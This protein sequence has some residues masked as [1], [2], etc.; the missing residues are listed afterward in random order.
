M[1]LRFDPSL[2]RLGFTRFGAWVVLLFSWDPVGV[3]PT[4]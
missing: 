4:W 1:M 3:V 2:L